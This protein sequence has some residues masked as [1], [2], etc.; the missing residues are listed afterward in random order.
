MAFDASPVEQ[1]DR[2]KFAAW[3]MERANEVVGVRGSWADC[4][5][6]RYYGSPRTAK[7]ITKEAGYGGWRTRFAQ[8]FDELT[9][10]CPTGREAL[11]VLNGIAVL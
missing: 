1:D 11:G 10:P 8:G 3:L 7:H 2:A 4:A 9:E 6:T 5:L